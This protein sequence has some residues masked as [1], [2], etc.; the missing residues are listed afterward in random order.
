MVLFCSFVLA[1]WT[2]AS[3]VMIV[4]AAIRWHGRKKR[5]L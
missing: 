2:V 1:V 3:W 4:L 5:R